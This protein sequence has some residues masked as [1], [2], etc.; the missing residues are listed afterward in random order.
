MQLSKLIEELVA[1]RVE[2]ICKGTG[3]SNAEVVIEID[4]ND[5][6]ETEAIAKVSIVNNKIVISNIK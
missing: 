5:T 3:I 6:I 1:K 4:K 2:L